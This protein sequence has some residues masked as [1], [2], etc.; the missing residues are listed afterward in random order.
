MP[1]E[2][3]RPPR[4]D[5]RVIGNRIGENNAD[6]EISTSAVTANADGS[7][8]ERLEYLQ[9]VQA[10]NVLTGTTD[11]DVSAS[12]YTT[13]GG[14]AIL[15]ITPSVNIA[16]VVVDL[17]L[18]KASTGLLVVNTTE[19]LQIMVQTKVDGT[20]WRTIHG[21]PA[22]SSM[23]GLT[24]PD[25]A[26]DLDAADD[27]PGHRF[28]IGPVGAG[29]EVRLT[30]QLSAETGGDAEIPYVVYYRGATAPTVTAVAAG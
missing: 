20:N 22:A 6:N 12:D 5:M 11:V 27:S 21:W 19:T 17:D 25:A 30:L 10:L 1:T 23:T 8:L 16:D 29:Q 9:S 15:T 3:N 14:I 18:N 7:I 24:V 28:Y 4:H 26:D 13:E 2:A